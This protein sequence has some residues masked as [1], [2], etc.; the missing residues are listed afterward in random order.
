LTGQPE[1]WVI[2]VGRAG[3]PR[4]LSFLFAKQR[5]SGRRLDGNEEMCRQQQQRQCWSTADSLGVSEETSKCERSVTSDD[6]ATSIIGN[7]S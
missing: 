7:D 3:V 6:T 2:A 1:V 4:L 5:R